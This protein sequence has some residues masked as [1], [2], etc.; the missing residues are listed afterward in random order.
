MAIWHWFFPFFIILLA[1]GLYDRLG[2]FN[3]VLRWLVF[4][5]LC[6]DSVVL[7]NDGLCVLRRLFELFSHGLL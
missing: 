1:C 7:C 5:L 2:L 4:L 6:S 3:V